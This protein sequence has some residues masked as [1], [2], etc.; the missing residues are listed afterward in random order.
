M[1]ERGHLVL[2]P[3]PFTDLSASKR[4]PVLALTGPDAY[5]DF[6]GLPVTSRPRAE[7]ALPLVQADMTDG[8]LPLASW[9]RIDRIV[10]LSSSLVIKTV[11]HVSDRVVAEAAERFYSRL[12][13]WETRR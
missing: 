11:G 6:I 9:I 10:T 5:G 4:R 7:H 12:R 2:V 1:F 3:Y 8:T 13:N